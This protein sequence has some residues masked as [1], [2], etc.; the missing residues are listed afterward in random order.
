MNDLPNCPVCGEDSLRLYNYDTES[1]LHYSVG[2]DAC[3]VAFHHEGFYGYNNVMAFFEDACAPSICENYG[4]LDGDEK[5][6]RWECSACGV[7]RVKAD[8]EPPYRHC[9]DCGA[10]VETW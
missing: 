7:K 6:N 9:P 4:S 3:G 2:C 5:R 1:G 10:Q 8:D